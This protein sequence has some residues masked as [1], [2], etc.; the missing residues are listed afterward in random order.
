MR[1]RRSTLALCAVTIIL[2][3]ALTILALPASQKD[4]ATAQN[5][6]TQMT[7]DVATL[8][9]T[10]DAAAPMTTITTDQLAPNTTYTEFAAMTIN[11][12]AAYLI[13]TAN[14]IGSTIKVRPGDAYVAGTRP[15]ADVFLA[16]SHYL[17]IDLGNLGSDRAAPNVDFTVIRGD[18]AGPA[19]LV[20]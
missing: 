5:A 7:T 20:V 14:D 13:G 12:E 18:H 17:Y 10:N 3:T 16:S 6:N 2:I 19:S 1:L 9:T 8:I 11:E 4:T 15:R